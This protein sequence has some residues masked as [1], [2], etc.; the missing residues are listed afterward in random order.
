MTNREKLDAFLKRA[1][2]EQLP[3]ISL[4][5]PTHR[6][7]PENQQDP[8]VYKNLVQEAEKELADKYPRRDWEAAIAALKDLEQREPDI[9]SHAQDGLAVLAA[10]EELET[11]RLQYAPQPKVV[12]GMAFHVLRLF[13]YLERHDAA[14]LADLG[15]DRLHTWLVNR[16][17]MEE[18]EPQGIKTSFPEL[19]DDFDANANLRT[20]SY[21]GLGGSF[22]GHGSPGE[23]QEKDR[24]KYFRY[25]DSAL[26][27]L[28]RE[29]GLPILL[30]GTMETITAFRQA[31][32]GTFYLEHA[33]AQPL[34]SLPA[35]RRQQEVRTALD[36]L[37]QQSAQKASTRLRRAEQLN[38]TRTS[39]KDIEQ[40]A[41]EGRVDE[42]VV[43]TARLPQKDVTLD[44]A[45]LHAFRSGAAINA[46]HEDI[47]G[48]TGPY[49]AILRY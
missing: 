4:Y 3:R 21:G 35:D 25:L 44:K 15:R 34:G 5:L 11:F 47:E 46:V 26:S 39:P 9:W 22:H 31:A 16:Y 10:G 33:I 43:N 24:D 18:F 28:H 42:L 36:P 37:Y 2:A 29:E 41:Q 20:G 1:R 7:P 14:I 17:G 32:K 8:I 40:A 49:T 38:L 30:A 48:L 23:E 27:Q 13:S 45:V 12:V 6:K 19:F